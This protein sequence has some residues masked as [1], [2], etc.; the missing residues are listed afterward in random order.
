M[1][2]VQCRLISMQLSSYV[3]YARGYLTEMKI[4][5]TGSPEHEVFTVI[6]QISQTLHYSNAQC[7]KLMKRLSDLVNNCSGEPT[8]PIFISVTG[9][10]TVFSTREWL[11]GIWTN[12]NW[13][14]PNI[15]CGLS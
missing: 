15:M 3:V 13:R 7:M 11:F 5:F 2:L 9:L 4:T 12:L 1:T 6:D 10:F 14:L 8:K